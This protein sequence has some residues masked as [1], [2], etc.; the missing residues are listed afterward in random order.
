MT[1]ITPNPYSPYATADPTTRHILP[2]PIF[3]PQAAA[4]VLAPTACERMAVVP[5]EPLRDALAGDGTL[6]EG[7]C[8]ACVTVMQ[9]GQPPARVSSECRACESPTWHGELCALCR[10]EKHEKWWPTRG[11]QPAAA[12]AVD[13]SEWAVALGADGLEPDQHQLTWSAGEQPIVRVH[14]AFHSGM[15]AES[16]DYLVTAVGEA[17]QREMERAATPADAAPAA[18]G[19]SGSAR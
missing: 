5:E 1:R 4:G 11:E 8:P 6:P 17:L 10:Q 18:A 3:F 14:F 7:L 16:R 15:R 13:L 19:E 9:G 12:A 2:S